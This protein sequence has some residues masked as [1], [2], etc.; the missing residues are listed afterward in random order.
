MSQTPIVECVP[1]FSEGRD[2]DAI[3]AI[4]GAIEATEGC[5]LLDVDPGKATH[6]T[7]VTF[8]G[9]PDDVVEGAFNAM[10]IAYERIDMRRHSGAHPRFG[11]TDVCPFVP[12]SGIDMDGC[13]DLA[14]RLG[15]RVGSELGVPVYLYEHAASSPERQNLATVRAGEYEGL[16]AKLAD[17]GFKPDYGPQEYDDN[18]ARTGVVA[19][20]AR[21]FL[22]AYNVNLNTRNKR[23]AMKIAALVREKGIILRDGNDEIVRDDEGKAVRT[24]G[25]FKAIKAIGWFIEEY[26]CCQ[27][28]INFVDYRISAPH[29]VVDAIR[30]VADKEGVVVTGSELVGLIPMDAM[31]RAG[32]HY[33]GRQGLTEGASEAELIEIAIRSLGLRDLT[34]FDPA[35]K[36]VELRIREDGPLVSMTNRQ[37]IDKLGSDSPAPGG[38]SVAALCG[39]MSAA[40]SAMVGALTV[41]KKGYEDAW[42]AQNVNAVAAQRLKDAYL[43]DVDNDTAAF[44]A[45]MDAFGLPKKSIEEKKARGRAIRA[46]T[47]HATLV[48]LQVLER[49]VEAVECAA[50]AIASGNKN[51]KSDAGVAALTAR[52]CAEG[53]YYNVCINLQ[54]LKDEEFRTDV[55]GR[56]DAAMAK[57]ETRVDELTADVRAALS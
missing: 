34:E 55:R 27:I 56:A 28:S 47:R 45:I 21:P 9:A 41:G 12:V 43:A 48:P 52:A 1:N 50:V 17:P 40:L 25:L 15:E 36:I 5:T 23:K 37:F 53:A 49:T 24:P 26:D 16:A 7:V 3:A 42:P 11:A 39:A 57:V 38:G 18:V 2:P 29:E 30:R 33:L 8:V 20:G 14:R 46:A 19:I 4:T 13:A 32:R 35:D 31:L 22:V 51:A 44:D 6:R 54:S 10:K